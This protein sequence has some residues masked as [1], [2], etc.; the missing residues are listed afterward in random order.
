MREHGAGIG[1]MLR[2]VKEELEEQKWGVDMIKMHSIC[3]K[4]GK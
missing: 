3:T 2:E 4:I 1:K